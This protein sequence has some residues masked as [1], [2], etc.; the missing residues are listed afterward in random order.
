MKN[1][2]NLIPVEVTHYRFEYMN[3]DTG[4]VV[5]S[6]WEVVRNTISN[7]IHYHFWSTNWVRIPVFDKVTVEMME[8]LF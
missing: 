5:S 8:P 2:T 1:T 4:E 7:L 6:R 3:N